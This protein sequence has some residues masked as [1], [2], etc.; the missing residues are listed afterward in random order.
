M[1]WVIQ[2]TV[3]ALLLLFFALQIPKSALFFHPR[4]PVAV[5][6]SLS[7]NWGMRPTRA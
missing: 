4:H 2:I 7:S 6:P 3:F 5:R 1:R